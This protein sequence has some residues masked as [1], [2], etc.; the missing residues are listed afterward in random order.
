MPILSAS[1]G[2]AFNPSAL[3]QSDVKWAVGVI[4]AGEGSLKQGTLLAIVPT[5]H[6]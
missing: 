6:S 1:A 2:L 5:D 4:K 3:E